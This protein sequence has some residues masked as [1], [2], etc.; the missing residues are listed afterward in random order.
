MNVLDYVI[1]AIYL[2]GVIII[3]L[4]CKS[5]TQTTSDYIVAGRKMGLSI[6]IGT[7]MATSIGGGVLNGW[8]GTVYDSGFALL[9][10]MLAI[11][12]ATILIG[13][14]LA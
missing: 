9:P 6:F 13:L 10:S 11:Y 5:K 1:I 7:Y 2:I 4:R 3:G 14:F 12:I 8:I